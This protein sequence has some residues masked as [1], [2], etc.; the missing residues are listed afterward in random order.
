VSGKQLYGGRGVFHPD[1]RSGRD[2]FKVSFGKGENGKGVRTSSGRNG[3]RPLF[4]GGGG[5]T[6]L[7][8]SKC[9]FGGGKRRFV[10]EGGGGILY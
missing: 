7:Y 2:H 9:L 5:V 4:L 3:T 8:G 1:F 10:K 6:P